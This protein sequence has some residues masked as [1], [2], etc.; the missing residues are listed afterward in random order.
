MSIVKSSTHGSFSLFLKYLIFYYLK[1]AGSAVQHPLM[2]APEIKGISLL[3]FSHFPERIELI[4]S[5]AVGQVGYRIFNDI[6]IDGGD[7]LRA[8]TVGL[9]IL[10]QLIPVV[11]HIVHVEVGQGGQGEG[12]KVV[13]PAKL[14]ESIGRVL[15]RIPEVLILIAHKLGIGTPA[16][17]VTA[18]A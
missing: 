17:I 5:H 4:A 7:I 12:Q 16:F 10:C 6:L 8:D 18:A 2:K 14:A 13:I 9:Q 1:R 15:I 3:F 11:T